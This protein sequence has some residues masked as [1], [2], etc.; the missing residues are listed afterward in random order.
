MVSEDS[1][2]NLSQYQPGNI[3]DDWIEELEYYLLAKFGEV[4]DARKKAA[5]ITGI[6]MEGKAVIKNFTANQKDTYQHLTDALK[7]H[8]K[9]ATNS[10]V[11]RNIFFNMFS[12]EDEPIDCFLTRLRT[13][14]AKCDFRVQCDEATNGQAAHHDLTDMFLRDRIV[15]GLFDV[16]VRRRLILCVRR[17]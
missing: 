13:Q 14:A 2:F 5:L 15:V 8:Y 9:P 12:E 16:A 10:I 17:N 4:N 11:E 1:S 6:G 7:E 3:I